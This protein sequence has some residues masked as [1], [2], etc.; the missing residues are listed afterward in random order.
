MKMHNRRHVFSSRK[1]VPVES[2]FLRKDILQRWEPGKVRGRRHPR[3]RSVR[4]RAAALSNWNRLV[5]MPELEAVDI[6]Q[7]AVGLVRA[8]AW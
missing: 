7:T 3:L 4:E 6:S 8:P 2:S 1:N 5:T